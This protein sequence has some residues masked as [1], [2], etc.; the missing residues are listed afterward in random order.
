MDLERYFPVS[1]D[2][3]L[4]MH[5]DLAARDGRL[6]RRKSLSAYTLTRA[7]PRCRILETLRA[8]L[9]RGHGSSSMMML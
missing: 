7:A 2:R 5:E 8:L 6:V 4:V 3:R 1:D 9:L